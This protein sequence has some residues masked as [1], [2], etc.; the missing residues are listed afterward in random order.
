M[1]AFQLNEFD[2][3]EKIIQR[4]KE[5]ETKEPLQISGD[6]ALMGHTG[7]HLEHQR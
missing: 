1:Q 4:I 6:D 3:L 2:G 7:S 5:I